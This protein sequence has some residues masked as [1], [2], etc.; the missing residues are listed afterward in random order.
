MTPREVVGRNLK[1]YREKAGLTQAVVAQRARVA[2]LS[3]QAY[4]NAYRS[5]SLETLFRLAD[6][7]GVTPEAL[8]KR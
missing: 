7:L 2:R 4:E 3:V 1:K 6:V 5:P 8:V